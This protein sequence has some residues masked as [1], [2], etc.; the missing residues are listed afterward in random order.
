VFPNLGDIAP[1]RAMEIFMGAIWGAI[2]KRS[3]K[4]GDGYLG[5]KM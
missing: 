2:N 3:D 4:G 5:A 1:W